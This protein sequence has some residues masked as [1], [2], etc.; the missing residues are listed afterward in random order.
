MYHHLVEG[1]R[2][3]ERE[4]QVCNFYLPIRVVSVMSEHLPLTSCNLNI[5]SRPFNNF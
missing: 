1:R 4:C 3:E 2:P 5:V